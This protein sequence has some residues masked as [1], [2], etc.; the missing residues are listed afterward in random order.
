MSGTQV[1]PYLPSGTSGGSAVLAPTPPP[2]SL[3]NS[4]IILMVYRQIVFVLLVGGL[5]MF[6]A[7]SRGSL[8]PKGLQTAFSSPGTP[9]TP[10][11]G[12]PE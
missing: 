3:E 8:I 7:P 9:G 2:I 4:N 1:K 5:F 11:I 10:G 6:A 12:V